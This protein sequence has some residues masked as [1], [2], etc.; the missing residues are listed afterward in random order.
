[1][2]ENKQND[3]CKN[4][5][6]SQQQDENISDSIAPKEGD[7]SEE[8]ESA[9]DRND[10]TEL[11]H[12]TGRNDDTKP[13]HDSGVLWGTINAV[14]SFANRN[15]GTTII[16]G[17]VIGNNGFILNLRFS[18]VIHFFQQVL[19]LQSRRLLC[20]LLALALGPVVQ[21]EIKIDYPKYKT[22]LL[23]IELC[24]RSSWWEYRCGSS[25]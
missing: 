15:P 4:D 25:V 21:M 8:G 18:F 22:N 7:E 6:E 3:V 9:T 10:Q 20:S 14:K 2:D 17:V 13:T 1:M 12:A 5:A 23:Y 24:F 19:L 11:L 16:G